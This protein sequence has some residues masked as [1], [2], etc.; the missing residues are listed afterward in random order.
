MSRGSSRRI[1]SDDGDRSAV[2]TNSRQFLSRL[3]GFGPSSPELPVRFAFCDFT[4]LRAKASA[5]IIFKTVAH[6]H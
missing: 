4:L 2:F 5:E 1:V 3:A 6:S